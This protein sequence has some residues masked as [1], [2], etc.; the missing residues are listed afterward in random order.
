MKFGR[1]LA[2]AFARRIAF[3]IVALVFAWIGIG[4]AR[5]TTP[6]QAQANC[7]TAAQSYTTGQKLCRWKQASGTNQCYQNWTGSAWRGGIFCSNEACPAGTSYNTTSNTCVSS[8]AAR[9][10]YVGTPPGIVGSTGGSFGG[11]ITNG[12]IQCTQPAGESGYC[13]V[14]WFD[15]GDGTWTARASTL[16]TT[17][18]TAKD[19]CE[20]EPFASAGYT[21]NDVFKTCQ[22]PREQ[23]ASNQTR[24]ATG[25][26]Q[27]TCAAGKH[28]NAENM[29]VNDDNECPAGN[30][31]SPEG[32]CLPGEGQCAA[33]EAKKPDGTCGKDTDG[34]GEAED[35]ENEEESFSGGDSCS[36][37]PSC[38]GGVID[39]GMAR[40]QW[41]IDCNTRKNRNIAGGACNAM[42]VCTGE[43]CDAL[44][45]S[46]LLMQWRTACAT[47]KLA[48][49]NGGDE[50]EDEDVSSGGVLGEDL[51]P[52]SVQ[53]EFNDNESGLD[54]SGFGFGTTCPT[55]PSVDVFGTTIEFDTQGIFCDWMRLGGVF[56]MIMAHLAGLAIIIRA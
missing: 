5:A 36:A 38:S 35:E 11:T 4:T 46:S 18:T 9:A 54:A 33:G 8:C 32:E 50:G 19:T 56:V 20:S 7:E 6:T 30:I 55:M 16:G 48:N 23:C 21:Y 17:C 14:A 34:D 41:R 31:K 42:P 15:N 49:A 24:D 44:E 47:E 28:L 52:E 40:I 2:N 29:C 12:S 27:D 51:D 25:E 37:P 1:I 22:P 13:E 26:C 53:T 43:K 3:V 45:Y 39:C 10:D